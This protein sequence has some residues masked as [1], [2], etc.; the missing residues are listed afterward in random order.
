L[1]TASLMATVAMLLAS[2]IEA[3]SYHLQ[4]PLPSYRPVHARSCTANVHS[5]MLIVSARMGV[6]LLKCEHTHLIHAQPVYA[7][8]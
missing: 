6:T 8:S 4:L 2:E 7:L 3:E 1:G 5:A